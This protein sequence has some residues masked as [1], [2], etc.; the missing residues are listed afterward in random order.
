MNKRIVIIASIFGIL[1]VV[2]GAFGAHG[3]RDRITPAELEIWKTA[4]DYHFYHTLALLFVSRYSKGVSRTINFSFISFIIGIILFS[5]SLYLLSTRTIT[6]L[7]W[8][9]LGPVTPI[10]GLFMILG[11]LGLLIATLRTNNVRV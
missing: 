7:N 9:F 10:G 8:S 6:G 1:A 4:V 3:L 11:W 2:M 5:G